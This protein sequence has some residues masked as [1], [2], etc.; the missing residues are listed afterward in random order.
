[1]AI[2]LAALLL[3]PWDGLAGAAADD[4]ASAAPQATAAAIRAASATPRATLG[5]HGDLVDTRERSDG[6]IARWSDVRAA[7]AA[8][9]LRPALLAGY[10]WPTRNARLTN[11]FG[12]GRP[13]SF[14]LNGVAFHDGIDIA[15][16]CGARITAAHDG[17]VL[18]A[19]R[20]TEGLL[21][22][23]GDLAPFRA[24]VEAEDAWGRQAITV[25]I[26]DGNGYRSI[27]A[28]LGLAVV[29]RGET[30]AAGDLLGYQ[31]ASGNATGCH[32]HYALF[33]PHDERRLTLEAKTARKTKLPSQEI[34]R[35]DP[36]LV[37]PPL[38]VGGITLGW[39]AR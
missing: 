39:G 10:Q 15:S 9:P 23:V 35:I 4:R 33:N 6:D 2:A 31:G 25:V 1:M 28:H 30:V 16:F 37:L 12:S 14:Q 21:G 7:Q 34:A 24:K 38:E 36:L 26:D 20:R 17:V 32:L 19:G 29:K 18:G 5:P 3:R 11:A 27:Y 22:W 13:S 8:K